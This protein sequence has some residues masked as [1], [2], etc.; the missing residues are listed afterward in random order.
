MGLGLSWRGR[1]HK[2]LEE[3]VQEVPSPESDGTRPGGSQRDL[4]RDSGNWE[5]RRKMS[6]LLTSKSA[7]LANKPISNVHQGSSTFKDNLGKIYH[8]NTKLLQ[9]PSFK[10]PNIY[11]SKVKCIMRQTEVKTMFVFS[12]TANS[13]DGFRQLLVVFSVS[14]LQLLKSGSSS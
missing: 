14:R 6:C 2:E 10:I 9:K 5:P 11:M 7:F 3:K 12:K 8:L 13:R 4:L 1:G